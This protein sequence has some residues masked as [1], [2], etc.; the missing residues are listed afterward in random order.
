[1]R[2]F[3]KLKPF[4]PIFFY[5]L[6]FVCPKKL[7]LLP[8]KITPIAPKNY[9]TYIISPFIYAG[10]LIPI[11][12]IIINIIIDLVAFLILLACSSASTEK[13]IA[14]SRCSVCPYLVLPLA[15]VGCGLVPLNF[16]LKVFLRLKKT[17]CCWV[18]VSAPLIVAVKFCYSFS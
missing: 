6:F 14:F 4:T 3:F 7:R 5:F 2:I 8:Q 16:K 12:N 1:M 17:P 10:F 18:S 15:V 9:A 11:I 13:I